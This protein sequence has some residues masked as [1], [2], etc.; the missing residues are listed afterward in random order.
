MAPHCLIPAT[1]APTRQTSTSLCH[2]TIRKQKNYHDV[3]SSWVKKEENPWER[4]PILV[5]VPRLLY[6]NWQPCDGWNNVHLLGGWRLSSTWVPIPPVPRCN[7]EW[8]E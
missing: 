4:V 7:L 5:N 2:L 1:L 8:L 3:S 6:D